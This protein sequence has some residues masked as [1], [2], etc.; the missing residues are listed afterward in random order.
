MLKIEIPWWQCPV[1]PFPLVA[2]CEDGTWTAQAPPGVKVNVEGPVVGD[3]VL[4]MEVQGRP[5]LERA[6]SGAGDP[7]RLLVRNILRKHGGVWGI[8]PE[9]GWGRL[10]TQLGG[11]IVS[12][13]GRGEQGSA[14][15]T[16]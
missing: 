11:V 6:V 16:V 4:D 1:E 3:V 8:L 15:E 7:T 14:R 9:G 2:I 10:A 13:S 5:A 12:L